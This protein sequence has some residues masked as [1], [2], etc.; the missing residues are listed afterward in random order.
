MLSVFSNVHSNITVNCEDY[1]TDSDG[2]RKKNKFNVKRVPTDVLKTGSYC[3]MTA[4]FTNI[5]LRSVNKR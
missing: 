5:Y 4:C 3:V 1:E 2:Y